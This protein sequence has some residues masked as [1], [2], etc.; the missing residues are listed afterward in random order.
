MDTSSRRLASLLSLAAAL[1]GCAGPAAAGRAPEPIALVAPG[2]ERV[3]WDALRAGQDFTLVVFW[4]AQCPCVR[5]YQARAD[6]LLEAF[7]AARVRVIGVSSN[8][9]E[10]HAES[11]AAARERGVRLPVYRDEGGRL[12][13]ALGAR[14]TPTAAVVDR[15]GELRYLGWIDNERV[16]GDP[17][18]EPWLEQAMAALLAGRSDH[19]ARAPMW[20]CVITR[21]LFDPKPGPGSCCTVTQ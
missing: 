4:S 15:G 8:V 13:E 3:G 7:P 21:S 14:S 5:R 2:G 6:S 20:G 11:L 18:R 17:K 10:P 19:R 9:G 12:A 1:A 16:P